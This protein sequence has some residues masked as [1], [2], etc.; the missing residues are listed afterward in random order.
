MSTKEAIESSV[1]E[2]VISE[3]QR[4][5]KTFPQEVAM[6]RDLKRPLG[7]KKETQKQKCEV[8]RQE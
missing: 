4:P 7:L 5:I 1:V 8:L 6:T 2:R 3:K